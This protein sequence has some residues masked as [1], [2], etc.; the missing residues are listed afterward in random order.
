MWAV[1]KGSNVLINFLQEYFL[2]EQQYIPESL[3]LDRVAVIVLGGGEGKRLHPLTKSRCKPTVPFGG[4]YALIDI[5]IS[6]ALI[7]GIRKIY[8]IGQYMSNSLHRYLSKTYHSLMQKDLH[9]LLPEERAGERIWYEGTADAVRKNLEFFYELSVDYFL[10]LSGDQLYNINFQKMIN[11]GVE[12]DASM[13]I[14]AQPISEK[15]ATRMGLLKLARNST[16]LEEFVEKPQEQALLDAFRMDELS[17]ARLG[18]HGTEGKHHLGSMGIYLFKRQALFDLLM[19][20]SR[21]DFGMHLIGTEMKK[22]QVHAYLYDGY[23]EDIGTIDSYYHANLA[24]TKQKGGKSFNCYDEQNLIITQSYHLP[25]AKVSNCLTQESLLCEGAI[26]EATEISNSIIGVR[27][28]VG[29]GC[30]IQDSI[31][32]GNSYYEKENAAT[33]GKMHTPEIGDNS[34]IKR[35]IIDENVTIGKNVL[36]VNKMN[37]QNFDHPDELL[38]VRDGIIVVPTKAHIPDHFIF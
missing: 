22:G 16:K 8:V 30:V 36:L 35:A 17:L 26:V 19:E 5:P 13:V 24:L 38:Y 25:G 18:Y 7:T 20:D 11:F 29:K 32:V 23:W 21:A 31:L 6:H 9:L 33:Q 12:S 4:R 28:K 3:P 27:S 15:E 1:N 37:Y 14:A 2:S 34:I 10:I